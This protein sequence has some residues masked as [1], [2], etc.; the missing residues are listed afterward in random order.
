MKTLIV[1][2]A[3]FYRDA[4]GIYYTPSVHDNVFFQ[5]YLKVFDQVRVI[6]RCFPA[7][8]SSTEKMLKVSGPGIEVYP[9]PWYQGMKELLRKSIGIIKTLRHAADG[10]E[11]IVYRIPQVESYLAGFFMKT[12]K[13]PFAV[14]VVADPVDWTMLHWFGKNINIYLLR[15]M[16]R[17]ADC[18]SYVRMGLNQRYPAGKRAFV[19]EYSSIELPDSALHTPKQYQ[20]MDNIR[21]IHVANAIA[22]ETK[23]HKV[24]M[25]AVKICRDE[26]CP[27]SVTFIGDGEKIPE[28]TEY[29]KAIGIEDAI[30]FAGR[31]SDRDEML[32]LLNQADLMVF[33]SETEGL[34]RVIIEAAAAG[35]PCLASRVGG[36]PDLLEEQYMF[37]PKD[38]KGYADKIIFLKNHPNELSEM[39]KQNIEVAKRYVS[40]RLTPRRSAFYQKL[41]NCIKNTK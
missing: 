23:G 4:E 15:F 29:A 32:C 6:G 17:H 9:L 39:S 28:F 8:I 31:I 27:A 10:C 3:H 7:T 18:V 41:R 22:N 35:L 37:E 38:A 25:D 24:L 26:G 34:P 13:K 40:S 33:P 12:R 5:R 19:T 11:C 1:T 14:E 36:I 16:V 20:S 30:R 2:C 21:L